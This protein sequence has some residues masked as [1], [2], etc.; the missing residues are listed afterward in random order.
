[1]TD[2]AEEAVDH[3]LTRFESNIEK[4]EQRAEQRWKET[5]VG[6]RPVTGRGGF[7]R[8]RPQPRRP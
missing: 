4:A 7:R 6:P 5:S 2:S 1:V 3:V 8:P